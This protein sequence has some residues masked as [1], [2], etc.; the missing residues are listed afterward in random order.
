MTDSG[1][2]QRP[3]AETDRQRDRRASKADN[4]SDNDDDNDDHTQTNKRTNEQ[5]CTGATQ[6]R[7]H[8][9]NARVHVSSIENTYNSIQ[10]NRPAI[11]NN[12]YGN[13]IKRRTR[14]SWLFDAE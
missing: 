6:E 7:L 10:Y 9:L 2:R 14:H 8:Q 13:L 5:L 1:H 11:N 3:P 4:N 12:Q